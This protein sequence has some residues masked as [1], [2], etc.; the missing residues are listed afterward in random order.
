MGL[1]SFLYFGAVELGVL[2]EL[3]SVML[4][5]ENL[6][7]LSSRQDAQDDVCDNVTRQVH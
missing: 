5:S 4:S 7:L 1:H 3:T 2:A 6:T